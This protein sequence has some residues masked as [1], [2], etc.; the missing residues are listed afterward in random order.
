MAVATASFAQTA[1]LQVTTRGQAAKPE[2]SIKA[3][4][5]VEK[6]TDGRLRAPAQDPWGILG[7][8]RGTYLPG[9]GALF[10][11][12]MALANLAPVTPFHLTVTPAEKKSG[13][14]RKVKN[15]ITLKAAMREMI[16]TAATVLAA[17]PADEQITFEAY[18]FSFNWEDHAGLPERVTFSA[19]RQK[20]A[21]AV[22]RHAT[23]IEM[24]SLFEER[25]E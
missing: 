19:S 13:H 12:E 25:S 4:K 7:D 5:E 21:D 23:A 3:L 11:F 22:A 2:I 1:V 10:T 15:L 20:V 14:D 24:A 6:A 8:A 17:M 16:V 18:L 9:Y